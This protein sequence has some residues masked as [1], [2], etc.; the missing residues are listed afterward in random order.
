MSHTWQNWSGSLCFTPHEIIHPRNEAELA[1]VISQA[2]DNR[3]H[4]RVVGSG[5][6]SSALVETDHVLISMKHFTGLHA[7]DANTGEAVIGAGSVIEDI[8]ETLNKQGLAMPNLGDVA[9]QTMA[10]VMATGTHGS[11]KGLQNL[12]AALSGVELINADGECKKYHEKTHSDF[13]RAVRVSL[14]TLGIYTKLYLKLV[15]AYKLE[16][17]EWCTHTE[18]ALEHLD[19]LIAHNRNF[20]FYWYPRADNVK[21]R[22]LNLPGESPV[23]IPYAKLV[24]AKEGWGHKI[25]PAHS[26][27]QNKFEEMEYALP[28]EAGVECFQEVRKRIIERH[29]KEVCWRLLYRIIAADDN[30]LSEM[31]GRET[32]T[33][34]IHHNAGLPFDEFFNDIEPI[35]RA[36]EGRP[37]WGKKH[38]LKAADLKPLYPQWDT[39]HRYRRESDPDSVFY[40]PYLQ[41]LLG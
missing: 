14:G 39:F 10:G 32:V 19:E 30:Y 4:V 8:L 37:H 7:A 25:I 11:G 5:H 31:Y 33:I 38:N 15:P 21:L 23:D 27:I 20:D 16:R 1:Q 13:M 40:T 12:S 18:D 6:S 35:F 2:R 41:E 29:R 9:T 24:K 36:Y 17:R 26:H 34:S 3:Q 22:L 28:I